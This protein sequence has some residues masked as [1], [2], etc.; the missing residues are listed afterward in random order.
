MALASSSSRRHLCKL[1]LCVAAATA[2]AA[3]GAQTFPAKPIRIVVG[4]PAGNTVDVVARVAAEQLRVKLG[5]PVVV[6]NRPGANGLI[7]AAEVARSPADGYTLLGSNSSGMTVNPQIHRNPGYQLSDFTPVT[8]M[9]SAP[10]ILVVNPTNE[11]TSAVKSLSDLVALARTRAG[12]LRYGSG[13]PG[14]I[15]GLSFEVLG[16]AANFKATHVPYKGTNA[17]EVGLLGKEVDALMDTPNGVPLIKSGKLTALAVTSAKRWRDLPDVPT[18]QEMGF[19]GFDVTF[20]LAIMAPAQTPPA[21]IDT[22]YGALKSI[23]DDAALTKQLEPHGAP[24]L[25]D[26]KEFAVRLRTEAAAWGE[27]IRRE[28]IQID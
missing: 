1:A 16:N 4:F 9:T 12:E 22:L 10:L 24:E 2:A 3:A 6:E 14:N 11:R 15:T 17:A 25:M 13:G 18:I 19:P 7:A 26:P 27:I 21:V 5:Q 8:M 28:K 23:R 20:W